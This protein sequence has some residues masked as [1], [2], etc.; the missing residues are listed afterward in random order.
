LS[1][2]G[3]NWRKFTALERSLLAFSLGGKDRSWF[4]DYQAFCGIHGRFGDSV[5]VVSHH[6]P[7]R[8]KPYS[9]L[10]HFLS[11]TGL[12]VDLDDL[13]SCDVRKN[14]SFNPVLIHS[15]SGHLSSL[16]PKSQSFFPGP[17]AGN[18]WIF[19]VAR[20][21]SRTEEVMS[22]FDS[23]FSPRLLRAFVGHLDCR[24]SANNKQYCDLMSVDFDYFRPTEDALLLSNNQLLTIARQ[25]SQ[26]RDLKKIEDLMFRTESLIMQAIRAEIESS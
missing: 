10:K 23:L 24:S 19:R 17:H 25:A 11:S 16:R 26:S 7:T 21:V 12:V 5:S 13:N 18:Q 14:L 2:R 9:L 1:S 22:E 20:R 8:S 4:S 6:I 3:L 15:I